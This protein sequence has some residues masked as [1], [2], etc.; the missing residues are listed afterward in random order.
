[1]WQIHQVTFSKQT[2]ARTCISS[3]LKVLTPTNFTPLNGSTAFQLHQ[4]RDPAFIPWRGGR[5]LPKPQCYSM[6]TMQSWVPMGSGWFLFMSPFYLKQEKSLFLP[7]SIVEYGTWCCWSSLTARTG[8]L[9]LE[10]ELTHFSLYYV[11]SAW[12]KTWLTFLPL[13]IQE[14][15]IWMSP[16]TYG[17]L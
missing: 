9:H 5:H 11:A 4:S 14:D 12:L 2:Q 13:N 16:I 10:Q 6:S 17:I 3:D 15:A 7:A 8:L 1:M